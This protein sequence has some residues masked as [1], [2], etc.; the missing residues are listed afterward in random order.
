MCGQ[1]LSEGVLD[2]APVMDVMGGDPEDMGGV[3]NNEL[4]PPNPVSTSHLPS[5]EDLLRVCGSSC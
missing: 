2:A 5:D 3:G 4:P 1:A